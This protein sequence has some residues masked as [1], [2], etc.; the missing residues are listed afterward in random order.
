MAQ[1][2]PDNRSDRSF[3]PRRCSLDQKRRGGKGHALLPAGAC[4]TAAICCE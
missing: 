4:G 3:L 2:L 1:A